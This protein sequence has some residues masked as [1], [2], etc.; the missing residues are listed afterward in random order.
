VT[1]DPC[2]EG[3]ARVLVYWEQGVSVREQ[4]EGGK[5]GRL[6]FLRRVCLGGVGETVGVEVSEEGGEEEAEE[7]ERKG[8]EEG[9]R[10]RKSVEGGLVVAEE[11]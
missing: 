7:V 9:V 10:R 5:Q 11:V 2:G 6:L 3:S 8:A 1:E 4:R